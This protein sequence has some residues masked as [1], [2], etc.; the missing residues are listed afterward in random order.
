MSFRNADSAYFIDEQDGK[1]APGGRGFLNKFKLERWM[2]L[3]DKITPLATPVKLDMSISGRNYLDP[4]CVIDDS[5]SKLN[6]DGRP[7]FRLE[8]RQPQLHIP[9]PNRN[10]RGQY[11]FYI[12]SQAWKKFL[13]A[14]KDGQTS[15]EFKVTLL[16]GTGNDAD[17]LGMRYYYEQ[18]DD[19]IL[20]NIPGIEQKPRWGIGISGLVNKER[21]IVL[22]QIDFIINYF[23]QNKP[24]KDLRYKI[25][26]LA[27]YSTGYIGLNQTVNE[28]LIP[29]E[30]IETVVYYD[31]IYR[32]DSPIPA[33]DD[34]NP[35][36]SLTKIERMY[37]NSTDELKESSKNSAYNTRRALTRIAEASK[38]KV[39]FVAY[40]STE[41]GSPLYPSISPSTSPY[42][43]YTVDFPTRIDL[44]KAD[45]QRALFAISITRCLH[46][47]QLDGQINSTDVPKEFKDLEFGL[48]K[49]GKIASTDLTCK[50]KG[51][52]TPDITLQHYWDK[53]KG[54]ISMALREG[55]KGEDSPMS[56][57]FRL[58]S[59]RQLIYSSG[60]PTPNNQ[61]GILH[62][63]LIPE[64]GWEYLI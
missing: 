15:P 2:Y 43:H 59:G 21:N 33:Q 19:R 11:G 5:K 10:K 54:K 17:N 58:I 41:G 20:I 44:R 47:A 3:S 55:K 23:L 60:Y 56:K 4:Y 22:N 48:P 46:Y 38:N 32:A 36:K 42:K 31:C 62:F 37:L 1:S 53:N 29:L 13:E 39:N 26:T 51:T 28:K 14:K 35:P 12:G 27:A 52:F 24:F 61:M 8:L 6:D 63:A 16:F 45:T 64:F 50:P 30:D 40:M 7:E 18:A 25:S 9:P 34:E 49:R 57:A